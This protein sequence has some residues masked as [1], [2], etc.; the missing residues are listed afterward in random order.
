MIKVSFC[1]EATESIHEYK[2]SSFT[3]QEEGT[4][5]PLLR[6]TLCSLPELV[7]SVRIHTDLKENNKQ[8]S[9]FVEYHEVSLLTDAP[10]PMETDNSPLYLSQKELAMKINNGER[11]PILHLSSPNILAGDRRITHYLRYYNIM[12]SSIWNYYFS[13]QEWFTDNINAKKHL[14]H[15]FES[16]VKNQLIGLLDAYISTEYASL[17]SRLIVNNYTDPNG[18][19]IFVTPFLFHSEWDMQTNIREIKGRV[20]ITRYK[21]RFLLVD[22]HAVDS[23]TTHGKEMKYDGK[24]TDLI[25]TSKLALVRDGLEQIDGVHVYWRYIDDIDNP[26]TWAEGGHKDGNIE[27][28]GV[29]NI[30]K[31]IGLLQ[32]QRFD[33]I[34]LDYLLGEVSLS[35]NDFLQKDGVMDAESEEEY[36]EYIHSSSREYGYHLLKRLKKLHKDNPTEFR[37]PLGRQYFMFISA[38][39]TAVEE[40]LRAE[41]LNRSEEFWQIGEGACPTN[42]PALFRYYLMRVMER[43]LER[44]GIQDLTESHIMQTVMGIYDDSKIDSATGRISAVRK[45][46][47][48]AYH[49]IL[50]LHYDYSV[51]KSEQGK[52]CL[53]DSFI[54]NKV[55][56]GAMLEHLLQLVHLT[57][58][59]TVRQWPEIWEEYKFFVRTINVNKETIREFSEK[60]EN[61][62]IVL[63]SA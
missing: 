41:G 10:G 56:M 28:W 3:W 45:N 9:F 11:Y 26:T 34:L 39:T 55:H 58:F 36:E 27:I 63:K 8:F 17:N 12:D 4:I 40:R 51:L 50:G 59:G 13:F 46:A 2:I 44:A 21:W 47:Y 48:D 29:T 35:R 60:I 43:R 31:A 6:N 25:P 32:N 49:I 54:E 18:H 30:K 62:I 20:D 37:G 19:G 42:T 38:F 1:L 16:I 24:S 52:S 53:I 57:A 15:I 22:D 33:I 5:R 14:Q 61:Y 23:I 7:N